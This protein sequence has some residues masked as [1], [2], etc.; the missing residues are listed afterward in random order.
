MRAT[1]VK[2][3]DGFKQHVSRSSEKLKEFLQNF[4]V[5]EPQVIEINGA[6]IWFTS[7]NYDFKNPAGTYVKLVSK[8]LY[9]Y[10]GSYYISVNFIEEVGKEDNAAIFDEVIKTIKVTDVSV[11][12]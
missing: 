12:K 2:N 8:I 5:T 1:R 3:F 4:V 7:A 6:K 11:K 9:I 10:R